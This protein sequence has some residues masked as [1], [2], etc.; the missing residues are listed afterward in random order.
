[1]GWECY[2][3]LRQGIIFPSK[4]KLASLR[5]KHFFLLKLPYSLSSKQIIRLEFD[6]QNYILP[7]CTL[8]L[9]EHLSIENFP[10]YFKMC[11]EP[12]KVGRG[13][14]SF[15][16]PFRDVCFLS[17]TFRTN[18]ELFMKMNQRDL[19]L[20]FIIHPHTPQPLFKFLLIFSLSFEMLKKK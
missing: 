7:L 6:K 5:H 8:P 12:Q 2:L 16:C 20:K 9:T 3:L 14:V 11:F 17:P 1:M 10:K 18:V 13:F 15:P 19:L 4:N